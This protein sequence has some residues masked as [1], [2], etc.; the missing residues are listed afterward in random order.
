MKKIP[1][2]FS[3]FYSNPKV[4]TVIHD[5]DI[6]SKLESF[7]SKIVKKIQKILDRKLGLDY[8]LSDRTKQ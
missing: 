1:F 5:V 7:Y 3:T 8:R 6:H 4:E 2:I